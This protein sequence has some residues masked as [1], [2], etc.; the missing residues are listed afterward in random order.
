MP[1]IVG[2]LTFVSRVNLVSAEFSMKNSLEPQARCSCGRT[3][4][5]NMF[6]LFLYRREVKLPKMEKI[7]TKPRTTKTSPV[8]PLLHR[9][10]L[11]PLGP[12]AH[13]TPLRPIIL[14]TRHPLP[15]PNSDRRREFY[16][17]PAE[18][19]LVY[20]EEPRPS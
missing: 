20:G 15:G 14:Q 2:I 12:T 16:S 19:R 9:P 17:H 5:T 1:T 3:E 11:G 6:I 10:Q 8:P 7:R 4:L 13:R 18:L